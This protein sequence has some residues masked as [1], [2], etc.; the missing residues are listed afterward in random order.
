MNRITTFKTVIFSLRITQAKRMV[1]T[2]VSLTKNPALIAS[3]K[4][5]PIRAKLVPN[6]AW[7]PFAAYN[8]QNRGFW[9]E[10]RSMSWD[11]T[12]GKIKTIK[13]RNAIVVE[14]S[15]KVRTSAPALKPN[16]A[17]MICSAQNTENIKTLNA[18]EEGDV[19]MRMSPEMWRGKSIR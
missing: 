19:F 14:S 13:I 17:R 6:P 18:G 7:I 12:F 11:C 16:L 2:V 5:I 4:E 15:R 1:V 3:V 10:Y 9:F 8:F